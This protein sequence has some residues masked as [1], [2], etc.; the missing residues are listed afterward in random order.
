[1][2]LTSC[3]IGATAVLLAGIVSP[4]DYFMAWFTWWAGDVSG[5]LLLTPFII[6]CLNGRWNFLAAQ[7]AK[8]FETL[9]LVVGL[10]VI[11]GIVFQNWFNPT[12][13]FTRAFIIL[14][15]LIWAAIRLREELLTAL[16]IV[17][18]L[19]AVLGT[20]D[21]VGPF[22]APTLNESL[23]TVDAFISINSIMV[24]VLKAA[25]L[26]TQEKELNLK[27]A[28]YNL[29]EIV[30]ERTQQLEEK[31]KELESRNKELA[32]FSYAASHDLQEP[33]RKIQTFSD[34]I[35][36]SQDDLSDN[37]KDLFR[38]IHSS[39]GRMKQLIENL[40]AYSKVEMSTNLF[41]QTDLNLV[42]E[43]V[44][45]ELSESIL[46]TNAIIDSNNLPRVFVI[47]FQFQQLFTN[48]LTNAI[49]FRK[50]GTSPHI[51]IESELVKG[52]DLLE[53]NIP[54]EEQYFHLS[55]RDNGIGFEQQYAEKIFEIFQRLHGQ[56]EFEGTGIGLAICRKIIET[57][58]GF[59]AAT[60]EPGKGFCFHIYLRA[61]NP[62]DE[63]VFKKQEIESHQLI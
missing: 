25:V 57:H 8:V 21:G 47:P 11:S 58:K 29:E 27:M 3:T 48:M 62:E 32:S 2:C 50:P 45:N 26:E 4:S 44:K 13:L 5:I 23:L 1:M 14:P 36:Q 31:N 56:S 22:I 33:L 46:A 35:L 16:L 60:G 30:S 51:I 41:Q 49:K 39:V 9:L 38:R 52:K 53:F 54:A 20:L 7:R 28:K 63:K 34:K 19:M 24:L 18:A 6:V 55:I 61:D 37:V 59:I 42:L 43:Q 12:F 10:T 15:L 17:S 40:L